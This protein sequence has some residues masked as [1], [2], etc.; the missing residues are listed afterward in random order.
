MTTSNETTLHAEPRRAAHAAAAPPANLPAVGRA[1]LATIGGTPLVELTEL[2]GLPAGTRLFAKLETRNPTGSVKDRPVAS[3]LAAAVRDGHVGPGSGR[4]LLDSS[5]GN[6]GIAYAALG[7]LFGVDVTLVVPGNASRERLER[8][9]AHGAEL[10]LTDPLEGYDAARALACSL[11]AD[12]PERYWY[13]NQ[14]ANDA[15]WRA[16]HD[17]TAGE[18][19]EQLAELGLG[20]PDLFVSGV[21]TGGTL[22]GVGRRLKAES[23]NARVGAVVPDLFPGI[24]GLK[25]LGAPGDRAPELFDASLVDHRVD[26]RLEEALPVCSELARSGLFVGPSSGA[27]VYTARRLA[28]ELGAPPIVATLLCDLGERYLSTGMWS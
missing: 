1:L 28:H 6:A 9:R 22:T 25:P 27:N 13:C 21:G 5:S 16:H 4:R 10:I 14:Y 8:I 3:M 15:N 18:L 23:P 11:A 7:P 2:G 20:A 17:G 26:V 24:E 19:L 12:D